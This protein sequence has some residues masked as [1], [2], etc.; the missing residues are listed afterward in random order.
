MFDMLLFVK[1]GYLVWQMSR[2]LFGLDLTGQ[3]S[4]LEIVYVSQS[5]VKRIS[6]AILANVFWVL[7]PMNKRVLP[8]L[9]VLY[10]FGVAVAALSIAEAVD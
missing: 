7:L 8:I 3:S 6:Y 1:F 9:D 5:L 2:K 10:F 4:S